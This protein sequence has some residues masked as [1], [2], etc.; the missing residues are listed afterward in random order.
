MNLDDMTYRQLHDYMYKVKEKLQSKKHVSSANGLKQIAF[1]RESVQK[2]KKEGVNV[3]TLFKFYCESNSFGHNI[4]P[5]VEA[6]KA[7]L[8]EELEMEDEKFEHCSFCEGKGYHENDYY[9]EGNVNRI[10]CSCRKNK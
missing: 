6:L 8:K 1:F 10:M 5:E 2:I 9:V 3:E 4:Y 7:I